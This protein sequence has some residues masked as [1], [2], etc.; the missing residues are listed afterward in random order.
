MSSGGRGRKFESCYSDQAYPRL[1]D[2]CF[3]STAAQLPM[4]CAAQILLPSGSRK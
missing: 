1:P 2:Y 4:K 3:V